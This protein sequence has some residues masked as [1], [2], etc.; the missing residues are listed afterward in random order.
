MALVGETGMNTLSIAGSKNRNDFTSASISGTPSEE[1]DIQAVHHQQLEQEFSE[2]STQPL[3]NQLRPGEQ[4]SETLDPPL[5]RTPKS[6]SNVP[7]LDDP[8]QFASPPK[9]LQP[10]AP[11]NTPVPIPKPADSAARPKWPEPVFRI[12]PAVPINGRASDKSTAKTN[13]A[14]LKI[15]VI[16]TQPLIHAKSTQQLL[17]AW[18]DASANQR[19]AIEEELAGRGFKHL[20]PK[21]VRQFLSDDFAERSRVVD[22]VL[23]E[24]NVDARPWL[25]LLA[26]DESADVRLL[27][28][29]VMATSDDVVLVEKA[30][31]TAVHDRDPR[32][33][34]LAGRLRDRR[35]NTTRR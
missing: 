4:E 14:P 29:T 27:A 17:Q 20:P 11:Q 19:P 35:T 12:L 15:K 25:L 16:E 8:N 23:T 9:P 32:I 24:P 10:T 2:I 6:N 26:E 3:T 28:I 7:P 5:E 13:G 21:L 33:A 22:T 30:W 18:Q 34:D 31:Q 1:P